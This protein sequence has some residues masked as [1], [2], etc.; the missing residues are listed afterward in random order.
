M[1]TF[2]LL[3]LLLSYPSESLQQHMDELKTVFEDEGL[4]PAKIKK[5]LFAFMD[6]YANRNLVRLQEDYVALFDRG[7]AHS[8]YLFEHI[9]GE[10][11]DRG[12]AMVDL[13]DH[14]IQHGVTLS[15][16]E[17]PDYLPVFLEFLSE[18]DIA[19]A[20]TLLGEVVHIIAGVGAKLRAKKVDYHQVFR[21]LE[22]L[23]SV[24]VEEKLR[25]QAVR[26]AA[27]EDTS[28]SAL[29]KEWED[30]PAFDGVG[31]IACHTCPSTI[32]KPKHSAAN[33]AA[34]SPM[35]INPNL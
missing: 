20:Q 32:Q 22:V 16:K 9:H 6:S 7:R 33:G 10:S 19:E 24:K 17:L 25:A 8:L 26:E 13:S 3:G 28:H 30:A 18:I 15:A 27:E 34:P 29:D 11:R 14:Y 21:A 5:P 35:H 4:I 12:Q 23:T 1:L 2:K 31:Q